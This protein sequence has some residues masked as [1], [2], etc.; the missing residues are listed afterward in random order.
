MA[1]V[2]N[3]DN[4]KKNAATI[5]YTANRDASG[6]VTNYGDGRFANQITPTTQTYFTGAALDGSGTM[7]NNGNGKF[8][9]TID[10]SKGNATPSQITLAN[11]VSVPITKTSLN[12]TS[13]GGDVA[14]QAA[15]AV[16]SDPYAS[17]YSLYDQ[18][19]ASNE[20]ALA[21]QRQARLNALQANYNNAKSKLDSSFNSGETEL[22]QNAD[23]DLREAY[24]ANKLNQRDMAQ[25]LAGQGVTGGAAESI[26]ANLYN[27]YGN[28]RNAIENNRADNLRALL[29]NYQ[30][31]LGDIENSYLSGMADADSDYASAI[32]NAMQSYYSNLADLQKQNIANQYKTALG[33]SGTSSSTKSSSD[34]EAQAQQKADEKK[35]SSLVST[36]SKY[37]NDYDTLALYAKENG[38][39]V[40]TPEGR[41]MFFAA[42]VNPDAFIEAQNKVVSNDVKNAVMNEL[43]RVTRAAWS[44]NTPDETRNNMI[45]NTMLRLVSQYGLTDEQAKALLA[46][47]GY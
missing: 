21:K 2:S 15:P 9:A 11:G 47:A 33:K 8:A 27:T 34:A 43:D 13:G 16:A 31:T 42:G 40:N 28:N 6:K 1:I 41:D 19:R 5:T 23:R 30:G 37:R 26:L 20:D 10:M 22:N 24:I 12:T 38:I 32:N 7:Q 36:M 29:A 4:K 44:N 18:M 25:Y 45:Y 46:E 3:Y 14:V 35:R 39:D 17:I